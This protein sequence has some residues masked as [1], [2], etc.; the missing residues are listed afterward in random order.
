MRASVITFVVVLACVAL[1]GRHEAS[2]QADV[3]DPAVTS[4]LAD[5][6]AMVLEKSHDAS[7]AAPQW[8][9]E[10]ATQIASYFNGTQEDREKIIDIQMYPTD[11]LKDYQTTLASLNGHLMVASLMHECGLRRY[12]WLANI[13]NKLASD[14]K[15]DAALLRKKAKLTDIERSAAEAYVRDDWNESRLFSLGDN[16]KSFCERARTAPFAALLDMYENG[17]FPSI[18][19]MRS[20]TDR[21]RKRMGS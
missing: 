13:T 19:D 21:L 8:D 18:W 15:N 16:P 5:E 2:K 10:R 1:V 4:S 9:V 6:P 14:I 3:K 17:S 7:G 12:G 20:Y 11:N